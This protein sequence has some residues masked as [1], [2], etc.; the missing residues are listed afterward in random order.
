MVAR[1]GGEM[2]PD[3]IEHLVGLLDAAE[4]RRGQIGQAVELRGLGLQHG[5]VRLEEAGAHDQDVA[6]ARGRVVLPLQGLE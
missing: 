6:E 2:V 4:P 1:D 5:V 3:P